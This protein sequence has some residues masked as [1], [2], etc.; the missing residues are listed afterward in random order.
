VAL[1][2]DTIA[3]RKSMRREPLLHLLEGDGP[4]RGK[5]VKLK[6]FEPHGQSRVR[7]KRTILSLYGTSPDMPVISTSGAGVGG[8][9]AA[10]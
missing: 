9:L 6:V 4:R 8:T 10:H 5:A 7:A 3:G 1:H 2:L